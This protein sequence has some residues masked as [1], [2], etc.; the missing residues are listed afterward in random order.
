MPNKK[1]SFKIPE[2]LHDIFC[3]YEALKKLKESYLEKYF[4]FKRLHIRLRIMRLRELLRKLT[5]NRRL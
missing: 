3:E 1:V 2:E 5:K 4:G